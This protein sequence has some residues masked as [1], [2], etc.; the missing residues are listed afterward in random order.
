MEILDYSA[1]SSGV[2]R[3]AAGLRVPL[4]GTLELT[5]R[6][7][8]RCRHCYNNLPAGDPAALAAEMGTAEVCRLLEEFAEAGCVWLLL[9]GGE[10]LLR[11]DFLEIYDRAKEKGF[12]LTLFTNATRVTA[13]LA[14]HLVGRP[15]FSIEVT[16][17][18]A[19][20]ATYEAVTGVPGSF[21]RCLRGI[22][23][24]KDRGLPL[25]LKSTLLTVNRHEV[26]EMKRFAEEDLGLSFRFD[27][28]L[29]ARCDC[30][31][32]PLL[33]RLTPEEVVALD[34]ADPEREAALR[35]L[36]GR[37]VPSDG[38]AGG[39]RTLYVCGGGAHSFAVDPYGRMRL[40]A[41]SPGEGYDLR[42][43]GFRDGW[44]HFLA[45]QRAQQID[46]GSK[47]AR[48]TLNGLCGMCPANGELEC[49]DPRQ[50]VDFLCRVAHLRA[51]ALGIDVAPH[52]ECDYCRGGAKFAEIMGA[53]GRMAPDAGHPQA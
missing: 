6:C 42:R 38:H 28:Q 50:P 52:G 30:S 24:L 5:R 22:A 36:A 20:R 33:V 10:I 21:G 9:T 27:A 3:R 48:C 29:N 53:A 15:P 37:G 45:R 40:C 7:N 18:G 35:E 4:G 41:L 47:C 26:W 31:Q 14:D 43:G 25:K 39:R 1:W 2:R 19:T 49:G 23:R 32:T 11:P 16:L 34:L 44:E 8:N 46:P 51:Y 12:L 17:Y 13:E